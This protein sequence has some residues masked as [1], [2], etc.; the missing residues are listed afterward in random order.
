M[1]RGMSRAQRRYAKTVERQ[2]RGYS[3]PLR[4]V[5]RVVDS[6]WMSQFEAA[7]MLGVSLLRVG[8]LIQGLS[9]EPAH[10]EAGQAG[11]TVKSVHRERQRRAD[12]G[13]LRRAAILIRDVARSL[14]RGL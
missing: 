13:P 14:V 9:L 5:Q 11:V 7:E 4:N 10:N 8:F 3:G 2:D 12:A 6:D 1:M